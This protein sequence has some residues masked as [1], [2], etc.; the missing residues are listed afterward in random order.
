MIYTRSKIYF[1]IAFCQLIWLHVHICCTFNWEFICSFF[2]FFS[3]RLLLMGYF[4]YFIAHF[5]YSISTWNI[6]HQ[7]LERNLLYGRHMN[8][9][10]LIKRWRIGQFPIINKLQHMGTSKALSYSYPLCDQYIAWYFLSMY[11]AHKTR[12]ETVTFA[13]SQK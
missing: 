10:T 6:W 9:Y 2:L 12:I 5:L 4:F 11:R 1:L 3:L 13:V 7:G 8:G